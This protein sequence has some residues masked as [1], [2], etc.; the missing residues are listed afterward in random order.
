MDRERVLHPMTIS[1]ETKMYNS[2]KKK[3]HYEEVLLLAKLDRSRFDLVIA[4]TTV[5]V[6]LRTEHA[7]YLKLDVMS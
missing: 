1:E 5:E 2:E 4:L 6:G 7:M 3:R